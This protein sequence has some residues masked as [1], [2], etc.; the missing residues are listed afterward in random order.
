MTNFQYSISYINSDCCENDNEVGIITDPTPEVD[1]KEN[2]INDDPVSAH[3]IGELSF[4]YFLHFFLLIF[5]HYNYFILYFLF[6]FFLLLLIR[7]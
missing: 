6:Y 1:D 4:F 7:M 3:Y 2:E 5:I